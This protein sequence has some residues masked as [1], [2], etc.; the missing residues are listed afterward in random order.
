MA[1]LRTTQKGGIWW[2]YLLKSLS[3]ETCEPWLH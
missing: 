1:L 2:A 3:E